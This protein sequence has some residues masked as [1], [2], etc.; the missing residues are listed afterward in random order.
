LRNKEEVGVSEYNLTVGLLLEYF[1]PP[2]LTATHK[3]KPYFKDVLVWA[4]KK[5]AQVYGFTSTKE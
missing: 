5:S 3:I 4:L 2:P 1:T